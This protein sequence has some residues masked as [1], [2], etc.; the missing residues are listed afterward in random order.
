MTLTMPECKY[1][2]QA[3][4]V[5]SLVASVYKKVSLSQKGQAVLKRFLTFE[6][7]K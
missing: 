4:P 2:I 1:T 5:W 6:G 7:R 3:T